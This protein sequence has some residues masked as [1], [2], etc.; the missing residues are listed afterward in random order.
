M[1]P[2]AGRPRFLHHA[3]THQ[4]LVHTKYLSEPL[5]A[6]K[7]RRRVCMGT[8]AAA[9]AASRSAV[10][11]G[12]APR[13][14]RSRVAAPVD[15]MH[16]RS[17]PRRA[18]NLHES[19]QGPAS[20]PALRTASVVP[21][22]LSAAP[23]SATGPK[24]GDVAVSPG[25][26]APLGPSPVDPSGLNF[27]LF[28]SSA[29]SVDL[30]VYFEETALAH[31]PS[32]RIPLDAAVN[33][34]GDTWHVRLDN[35]PRGGGSGGGGL[36]RYGFMVSG[37]TGVETGDRWHSDRVMVDPYAPLVDGRRVFGAASPSQSS[38]FHLNVRRSVSETLQLYLKPLTLL[39]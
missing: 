8:L 26:P 39:D 30:C 6:A 25:T 16:Q 11:A 31:A 35:V 18:E 32:M 17:N 22:A 2:G 3:F 24:I 19:F 9:L 15:A 13:C 37:D 1:I 23:Q 5:G 14:A 20:A 36:V 29:K 10:S 27:A 33:K 7:R 21:R 34:T 12:A 28:S 4:H 38:P